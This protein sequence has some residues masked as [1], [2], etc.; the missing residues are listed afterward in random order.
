[1]P[2]LVFCFF[3]VSILAVVTNL[4]LQIRELINGAFLSIKCKDQECTVLSPLTDAGQ[5][6][7]P[8]VLFEYIIIILMTF[9]IVL[10]IPINAILSK[11]NEKLRVNENYLKITKLDLEILW[12][13]RKEFLAKSSHS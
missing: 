1:M 3:L 10:I 2:G 6:F 11:C 4:S 5:N 13:N 12:I 7:T 8:H 9:D